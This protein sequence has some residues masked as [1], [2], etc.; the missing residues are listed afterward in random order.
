MLTGN[1]GISSDGDLELNSFTTA[2]LVLIGSDVL[3][4]EGALC[5]L[6]YLFGLDLLLGE[7]SLLLHQ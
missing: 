5:T 1:C 3:V 2:E 6:H 4:T 7:Q